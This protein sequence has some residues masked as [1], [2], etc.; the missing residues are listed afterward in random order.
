MVTSTPPAK[1][2]DE[3]LRDVPLRSGSM[4]DDYRELFL[5]ECA[6]L[7]VR[8]PV[9]FAKGAFPTS[10]N[11]PLMSDEE[12]HLVGIRYKEKGQESAIEL[13]AELVSPV[14]QAQRVK[15]WKQFMQAYPDARLYCFRGGLRSRITQQWLAEAG[16]QVPL[17]EG[18]Y[19]ALRTFLIEEMD[20]LCAAMDFIVVGG[21]TGNGKTLLLHK[22]GSKIDLEKLAN[23]RGSSFG[24]MPDDQQ[25]RNIDFENTLSVALMRMEAQGCTRLFLEDEAR[26]IGR[27][28]LPDTLRKAMQGSPIY[29]LECD[30]PQR[31]ENCF[32]DYVTE[33]LYAY[34]E[35]DGKQAGFD[36]Y[37][38]HHR[39]SL[40]RI[41]KRFGAENYR[42]ALALLNVALQAH[43]HR[44]DTSRYRE[45]IE[46]LLRDY[47]DPMYDYQLEQKADRVKFR[48]TREQILEKASLQVQ[49][50]EV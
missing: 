35:Q 46:L 37:A 8:A 34:Q 16:V 14:V 47:Y 25:P 39:Q 27:V 45:F 36:A 21:R 6:L 28:C 10:V 44:G 32:D 29:I 24:R 26:L 33:L 3:R 5:S 15:T 17:V 50:T 49:S 20:R 2:A 7:D 38:Q 18:G 43:Q 19:K 48:G 11:L 22:L 12:R 23:H 4:V 30:M 31:I 42:N 1:P 40:A 9:E 41:Q 13:G